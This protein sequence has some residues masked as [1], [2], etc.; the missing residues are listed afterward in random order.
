M[1]RLTIAAIMAVIAAGTFT[2]CGLNGA[3]DVKLDSSRNSGFENAQEEEV[4]TGDAGTGTVATT[5]ADGQG[6]GTT[7]AQNT[8][9]NGSANSQGAMSGG[10]QDIGRDA[11]L[12]AALKHSGVSQSDTS[13]LQ[14]SED[15]DDGRKVYDVRFDVG[16]TEYDYEIL[17]TDGQ[18]LSS[19]VENNGRAAGGTQNYAAQNVAVSQDQAVA[20]A[21]ERVPGATERDIRIELDYDDGVY[22]YEGNII[23]Q[24]MEYDFEINA[25]SGEV[26]GWSEERP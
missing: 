13:R 11:A 8:G 15:M 24:Q 22:K 23:Y 3:Q 25:N 4:N 9:N 12:Q 20:T 10:G 16:Q 7:E 5:P 6:A 19:D 26:M 18:I 14:I 21:L 17:S 2:G 1:K